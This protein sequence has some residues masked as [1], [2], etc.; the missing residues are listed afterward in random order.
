M[1]QCSRQSRDLMAL[2]AAEVRITGTAGQAVR[3]SLCR[4]GHHI[5]GPLQIIYKASQHLQLLPILLTQ[6]QMGG[7]SESKKPGDH[8]ADPFKVTRPAGTAEVIHQLSSWDEPGQS[9]SA[10]GI[11]LRH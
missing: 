5:E 11:N 4:E 8:S 7:P 9:L 2:L 6:M 3:F 1:L 10:M